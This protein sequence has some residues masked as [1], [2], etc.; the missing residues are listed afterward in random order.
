MQNIRKLTLVLLALSV[1]LIPT[2]LRAEGL[3]SSVF[4]VMAEMTGGTVITLPKP[5]EGEDDPTIQCAAFNIIMGTI[6]PTVT[7]VKPMKLPLGTT[8]NLLITA[9]SANF[10]HASTVRILQADERNSGIQINA[11]EFVSP[12]KIEANVTVPTTTARQF[13]DVYVDSPLGGDTETAK[14]AC[15]LEV[16]EKPANPLVLSVSPSKLTQNS[17][18]AMD[19]YGS[20]THFDTATPVLNLGNGI[21]ATNIVVHDPAF[22]TATLEVDETSPDGFRNV[23]VTTGAEVAN[24]SQAGG[25]VLV[26][27]SDLAIPLITEVSPLQ[28]PRDNT[29]LITLTGSKT[30]FN[31][32]SVVSVFGDGVAVDNNALSVENETQI[33]APVTI[34]SDAT[35]G[36][37]DV[38]VTTGAETATIISGLEI[39]PITHADIVF[40]G[41]NISEDAPNDTV[42]GKFSTTNSGVETAVYTHV[43]DDNAGG[44]FKLVGDD[45]QVADT[46][47]L[48]AGKHSIVVRAIYLGND[49][50]TKT[51]FIDVIHDGPTS[52]VIS[53]DAVIEKSEVGTEVGVFSTVDPTLGDSHTYTLVD[54]A[55]GLFEIKDN[56]LLVAN[57]EALVMKT[58][59]IKVRSTDSTAKSIDKDFTIKVESPINVEPTKVELTNTV[60]KVGTSANTII[61][62]LSSIDPNSDDTHTYSLEDD[63]DEFFGIDNDSL[64]ANKELSEVAEHSITIRTTDNGGLFHDEDFTITVKDM[65]LDG[66][67][68]QV[69]SEAGTEIGQLDTQGSNKVHTYGLVKNGE[70]ITDFEAE[71]FKIE[72]DRLLVANAK[73]LKVSTHEITVRSMETD[74][75]NLFFDKG[76]TITVNSKEPVPPIDIEPPPT[77][78][79]I[80]PP[81]TPVKAQPTPTLDNIDNDS[82]DDSIS[83]DVEDITPNNGDGNKADTL[84]SEVNTIAVISQIQF[85]SD[86]EFV[87]DEYATSSTI[88]SGSQVSGYLI[89]IPVTRTLGKDG[90]VTV[91]YAINA[92]PGYDYI[93]IHPRDGTLTW[94][95]G[96]NNEQQISLFVVDEEPLNFR[97]ILSNPSDNAKLG[98]LTQA[99]I[100]KPVI[101]P[102][103]KE[104]KPPTP[105]CSDDPALSLTPA[106]QPLTLNLWDEPIELEIS[107]GQNFDEQDKIHIA[108]SPDSEIVTLDSTFPATGGAQFT[109][110]P[111]A[112]GTT[113]VIV[114]DC[115]SQAVINITVKGCDPNHTVTTKP[116]EVTLLLGDE[117]PFLLRVTGD[118]EQREIL[119]Y[120]RSDIVDVESSFTENGDISF[121]LLTPVA[122][123]NGTITVGNTCNQTEIPITVIDCFD[124]PTTPLLVEKEEIT[125]SIEKSRPVRLD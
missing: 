47:L 33:S 36:Y 35:F 97:L 69:D 72:Y 122:T 116:E 98:T 18:T 41:T 89:N 5:T 107:G 44:R 20:N 87:L 65:T 124:E 1:F 55:E 23:T 30:H 49:A 74:N 118:G 77:P 21:T 67:E 112:E 19:I 13:Y 25:S 113:Q 104:V 52:I 14:G 58:Y 117:A 29:V 26:L 81:P 123:G 12:S 71:P 115:A 45:L 64:I 39:L 80:E 100:T 114:K 94:A 46:S 82:N 50:A 51:F 86:S 27:P 85:G 66:N 43:L 83:A 95:D 111:K 103:T 24:D 93:A 88:L 10:N 8:V 68:I 61:A 6:K 79:D 15:A 76:F 84:D 110:T 57:K 54:D 96:D 108:Q 42:I 105:V 31:S 78:V 70:L 34:A 2:Q 37:R 59:A 102:V 38:S 62:K 109:F 28:V 63:A 17:T 7:A 16:I 92:I 9:P 3:S 101:K 11:I 40:S 22:L 121:L 120:P 48:D 91:D 73:S 125:L 90:I 75:E 60:A 32:S 53:S 106:E 119:D 99:T 4:A 56:R